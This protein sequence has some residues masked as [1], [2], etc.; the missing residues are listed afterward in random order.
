MPIGSGARQSGLTVTALRHYDT[1]GLL[2]PAGVDPGTGHRWYAPDRLDQA[3][4]RRRCW[5]PGT[6]R[7]RCAN[8]QRR[9]G[10]S[11]RSAIR[12]VVEDDRAS[13]PL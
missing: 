6:A 10:C 12:Q 1:F 9:A 11:M 5:W 7:R 8:A 13:L 2:P 4:R 3:R